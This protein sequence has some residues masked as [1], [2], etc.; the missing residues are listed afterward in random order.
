MNGLG[1]SEFKTSF[2]GIPPEVIEAVHTKYGANP[3]IIA[4]ILSMIQALIGGGGGN[5]N[6]QA[7]IAMVLSF[8]HIPVPPAPTPTPNP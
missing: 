7:I 1:A 5:I 8:F 6:L 4:M 2:P 3:A